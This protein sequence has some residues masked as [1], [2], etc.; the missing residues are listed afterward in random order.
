M[1]CSVFVGVSVDGFL[2]RPD[3]SVDFLKAGEGVPHG[4]DEFYASIDAVVIGRKTFEW[5]VSWGQWAYGDHRVVAL[6]TRPLD[7]SVYPEARV[8]QMSGEPADIIARLSAAGSHHLYIDGGV[9]I[10]RFLRAGCIDRLVVTRVPV[11][12]GQGIPLFGALTHDILLRHIATRT[13]EAGL[14]Q[15]EY[16]IAAGRSRGSTLTG[17]P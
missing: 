13:Y 7:F 9:T 1:P 14:V 6:S 2:A 17:I 8:E 4:F 15:S 5:V 11:L 16:E 3:G 10:Q 12:I